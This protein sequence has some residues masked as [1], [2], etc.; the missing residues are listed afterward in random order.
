MPA[1]DDV[2]LKDY[3][4]ILQDRMG[5]RTLCLEPVDGDANSEHQWDFNRI[6]YFKLIRNS[7]IINDGTAG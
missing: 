6:G 3:Y 2:R 1:N 5:M 7:M 4:D